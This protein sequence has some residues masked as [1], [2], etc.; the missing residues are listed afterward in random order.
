MTTEPL[1]STQQIA[2]LLA[3]NDGLMQ[4]VMAMNTFNEK[5]MTQINR[6]DRLIAELQNNAQI[7]M[8][9]S[10]KQALITENRELQNLT[11]EQSFLIERQ[12]ER[13]EMLDTENQELMELLAR[14]TD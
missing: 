4:S 13:I 2:E 9:S 11:S 5:L 8:S 10:S 14:L 7:P 1:L 3:A 6:K 12:N